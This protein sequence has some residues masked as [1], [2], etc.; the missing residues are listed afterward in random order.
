MRCTHLFT[1]SHW[2]KGLAVSF[3]LIHGHSHAHGC[4]SVLFLLSF[5]ILLKFLFH[6]FLIPA[7][8]P[9]DDSMNYPCATPPSGA[10][11]PLTMSHPTHVQCLVLDHLVWPVALFA[12]QRIS[13]FARTRTTDRQTSLLAGSDKHVLGVRYEAS[14]RARCHRNPHLRGTV[15]RGTVA[16]SWTLIELDVT[17][18]EIVRLGLITSEEVW[19]VSRVHLL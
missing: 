16:G 8:V 19:V 10:W 6:L 3:H 9:D 15:A 18:H 1:P 4:L 11:S 12:L 7:M 17:L 13:P 5:Y 14:L 2:L